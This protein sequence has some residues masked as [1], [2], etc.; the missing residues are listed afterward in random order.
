MGDRAFNG[1]RP[2]KANI[3]TA[4]RGLR[5]NKGDSVTALMEAQHRIAN[6]QLLDSNPPINPVRFAIA[7]GVQHPFQENDGLFDIVNR[8]SDMIDLPNGLRHNLPSP[9][10]WRTLQPSTRIKRSYLVSRFV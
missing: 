9:S 3:C 8:I 1:S 7:P 2:D 4:G 10:C 6:P 5:S